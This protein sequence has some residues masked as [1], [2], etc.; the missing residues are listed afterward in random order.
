LYLPVACA[1]D[2]SMDDEE[3]RKIKKDSTTLINYYWD[4][5]TKN[6]PNNPLFAIENQ[7]V[8]GDRKLVG[9]NFDFLRKRIH[10]YI[11]HPVATKIFKNHAYVRT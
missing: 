10:K 3:F 5:C 1:T 4:I 2:E 8:E 11:K 6:I 7:Y 9:F